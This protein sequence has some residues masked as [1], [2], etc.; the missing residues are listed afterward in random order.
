M[1]PRHA[2]V[3]VLLVVAGCGSS[4]LSKSEF[5][6]KADRVCRE[7]GRKLDELGPDAANGPQGALAQA[8]PGVR[9]QGERI[10]RL[11][12]LRPP[13]NLKSSWSRYLRLLRDERRI[14]EQVNERLKT[15]S[16]PPQAL[17]QRQQA[18]FQQRSA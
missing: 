7:E 5:V 12:Q 8:I 4:T 14:A 16:P 1:R 10:T 11:Q 17:A 15:G 18:S 3:I 2:L 9:I 13:D 6:S